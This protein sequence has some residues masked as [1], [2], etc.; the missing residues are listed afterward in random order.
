MRAST[1]ALLNLAP[2]DWRAAVTE[3]SEAQ[4]Y[5]QTRELDSLILR[6][7]R[8][9]GYIDGRGSRPDDYT[10]HNFGVE[11]SNRL[12]SRVRKALGFAQARDDIS[13]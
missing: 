3:L 8:L 11:K 1:E 13:F 5:E 12:A 4:R 7:T 10:S 9:R 2:V 6:A